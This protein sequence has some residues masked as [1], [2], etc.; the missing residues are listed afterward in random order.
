MSISKQIAEHIVRTNFASID[1]VTIQRAKWRLLDAVGCLIAG[2]GA[3]G[4]RMMID[5]VTGWGGAG[6]STL[7][8]HNF[9][10]PAHNVAMANSLMAR[11]YDYEPVEADG[12]EGSSPAHI[13][14]TTV[15]TAI[16][17]AE[18]VAAG[19]KELL[20]AL[21]LGDD[22]ASR[23]GVASGFAFD[24]G[25]DN[26]GTINALGATAVAGKLLK[27]DAT[28]VLNALGIALNQLAGSMAGVVDK[29]VAFKLPIAFASRNGIVSAELAGHGFAG[30]KAPLEGDNGFFA[31]YCR[32]YNMSRLTKDL[33]QKFYG[34]RVI[35]P[36]SCCRANH[37]AVDSA[38]Q[39]V[40]ANNFKPEDIDD[41]SIYTSPGIGKSFVGQPYQPGATPQVNGAFSITYTVATAI[42]RKEVTPR[43]FTE[44]NIN[45]PE[46]DRL[47]SKIT[48][49]PILP[50]E[51]RLATEMH[52]KTRDGA[53]Y[54]AHTDF[55]AGDFYATPLTPEEIKA[56]F[57]ANAAFSGTVSP[58]KAE[59]AFK[60]VESLEEL[61]D[62]R[63]LTG[64][65]VRD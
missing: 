13:S 14:G 24:Q 43:C 12:E 32:D 65:L 62:V 19:G 47:I 28:Q 40:R 44:L 56:K 7:L 58:V 1:A 3:P 10:G 4:C 35:K 22:L 55:P 52:I 45:D 36:Y 34:D 30:V 59:K 9:K 25:W 16:A 50:R 39:I 21:V 46:I 31:L 2:A 53:T 48:I 64:L 61:H 38:L 5:L 60:L 20:N 42:L 27:L 15:P 23:L 11:S 33:G 54:S 26:T 8:A 37:S 49:V 18:K 57:E 29:T 51:K 41:I 17:V 6:E 63:E